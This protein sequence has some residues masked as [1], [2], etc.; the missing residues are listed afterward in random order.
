MQLKRSDF[1]FGRILGEGAYAKVSRQTDINK[2]TNQQQHHHH[3]HGLRNTLPAFQVMHCRL[4]LNKEDYAVKVMLMSFIQREGKVQF[5]MTE[6]R[7]MSMLDH[8][9]VVKLKFAFKVSNALHPSPPPT[10][11]CFHLASRLWHHVWQDKRY[12]YLVM[13]L[14]QTT[15]LSAIQCVATTHHHRYHLAGPCTPL[16]VT[17]CVGCPWPGH[18][19]V[20]PVPLA[21]PT[22]A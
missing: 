2:A 7:V 6:K 9:N 3:C 8:P 15:L 22:R 17:N 5:V 16:T 1:Q 12:L 18:S 11:A 14:C 21:L 4:K 13:E 19:V 10:H 20:P